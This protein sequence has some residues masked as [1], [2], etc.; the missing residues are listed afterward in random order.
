MCQIVMKQTERI[1]IKT[2]AFVYVTYTQKDMIKLLGKLH[3][4]PTH[5]GTE[6]L[7]ILCYLVAVI[8]VVF[9]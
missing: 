3:K 5:K 2:N 6:L 9:Q 4:I 8:I 7:R 1:R